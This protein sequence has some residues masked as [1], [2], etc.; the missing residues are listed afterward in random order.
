MLIQVRRWYNYLVIHIIWDI[1]PHSQRF[2]NPQTEKYDRGL[3][4]TELLP[5]GP[6]LHCKYVVYFLRMSKWLGANFP[7]AEER[8]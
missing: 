7:Q 6:R 2:I 1:R 8:L 4:E 5:L 3:Q